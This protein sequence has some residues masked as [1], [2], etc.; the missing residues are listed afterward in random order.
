MVAMIPFPISHECGA[1]IGRRYFAESTRVDGFLR[2]ELHCFCVV[3][4][5]CGR[6][7]VSLLQDRFKIKKKLYECE[8]LI[9]IPFKFR[10]VG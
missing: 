6:R 9:L 1:L 5:D 7:G 8:F 3:H 4:I 2:G 10:F